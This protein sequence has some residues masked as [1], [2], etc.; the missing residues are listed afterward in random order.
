MVCHTAQIRRKRGGRAEP[1]GAP[2]IGLDVLATEQRADR[3]IARE[4]AMT[5]PSRDAWV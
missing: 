3:E 4:G 5:V 2:G 1:E